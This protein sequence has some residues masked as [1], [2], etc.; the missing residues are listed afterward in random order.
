M[1]TQE[2]P[3]LP[4]SEWVFT[5]GTLIQILSGIKVYCTELVCVFTGISWW[6]DVDVPPGTSAGRC[7]T[8]S[9][10]DE[11]Q[12]LDR[13]VRADSLWEESWCDVSV[14]IPTC[15]QR[16]WNMS[17][18]FCVII[19]HCLLQ[20]TIRSVLGTSF[21]FTISSAQYR[22]YPLLATNTQLLAICTVQCSILLAHLIVSCS[23]V[24]CQLSGVSFIGSLVSCSIANE[25]AVCPPVTILFISSQVSFEWDYKYPV[26]HFVTF[27]FIGLL[28]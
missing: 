14:L 6:L 9:S 7:R 28:L 16:F 24:S 13:N 2:V 4:F 22:E 12:R 1:R 21:M 15:S 5:W 27:L 8:A 11:T 23:L 25:S 19:F 18:S 20:R 10:S 3:Y 17:F 26:L